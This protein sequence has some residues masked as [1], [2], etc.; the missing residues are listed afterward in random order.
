M[1][2]LCSLKLLLFSCLLIGA[3]ATSASAHRVNLFAYV[4]GNTVYTESYFSKKN[5]VHQGKITVFE[6][7][8][9]K[10][11]LT[12][13]TDDTGNF[14]F[15]VPVE[16][17]KNHTGLKIVLNASQ[18]HR[19]KWILQADEIAPAQD[20]TVPSHE[21]AAPT[22][23]TETK[24]MPA[25]TPQQQELMLQQFKKIDNKLDAIKRILIAEQETG[26]SM[27]DVISG[28]GYILGLFGVAAF[29]AS[30]RK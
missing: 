18:G 30:K 15:P 10:Q 13:I 12:G 8:N 16:V 4:E 11:L 24:S 21:A 7:E 14:N 1:K 27:Q 29:V 17:L 3:Y 23:K 9:G 5:R 25:A 2:Y 28:I 22:Q 26:P 19:N 6:L 20:E